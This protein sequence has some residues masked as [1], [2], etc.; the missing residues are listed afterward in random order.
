MK[1]EL[2]K[3]ELIKQAFKLGNSAGVLLPVAWQNRKVAVKLVE[4]SINQEIIEILEERDILKNVIGIYLTGSYARG[5]ETEESDIDILVITDEIDKQLKIGKYEIIMVSR[6]KFEKLVLK[7]LY[8]AS[9]LFEAKTIINNFYL[10][11]YRDKIKNL[12]IKNNLDIIKS[13]TNINELNIK[14]DEE[15][16]EKVEDGTV[17]S[18]VL[19]LRELYIIDCLRNDKLQTKK[20]F[21]AIIKKIASEECY[22]AYLRIKNDARPKKVI[23]TQEALALVYEIKNGKKKR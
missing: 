8:Y 22:N 23:L 12:T 2:I 17:Y 21:L 20:E 5:E 11:L 1:Q 3:Q 16:E 19:R 13:I 14:I 4:R 6:E 10:I 9:L 18:L 15:L 7:S